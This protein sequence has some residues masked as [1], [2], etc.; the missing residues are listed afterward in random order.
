MVFREPGEQ[1]RAAALAKAATAQRARADLRER[2]QSGDR[3]LGQVIGDAEHDPSLGR[4][5]V[6]ELLA[7]LPI[8]RGSTSVSQIMTEAGIAP[9]RQLRSLTAFQRAALL[10]RFGSSPAAGG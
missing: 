3:D 2:L 6:S 4:M 10:Q 5:R 9:T 7:A 8:G 1:R